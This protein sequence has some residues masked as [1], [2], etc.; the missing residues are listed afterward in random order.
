MTL[1]GE[2]VGEYLKLRSKHMSYNHQ[3]QALL[4]NI[5]N[6][7]M[8]TWGRRSAITW[9]SIGIICQI[10][11]WKGLISWS[12]VGMWGLSGIYEKTLLC[13][14]PDFLN[15]RAMALW[16]RG[17]RWV[18]KIWKKFACKAVMLMREIKKIKWAA[19]GHPGELDPEFPFERKFQ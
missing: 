6:K 10:L 14:V 9:V 5:S 12:I 2:Y 15:E 8:A 1:G 19:L 18:I 7:D 3:T 4:S 11:Y 16:D 13:L 17:E